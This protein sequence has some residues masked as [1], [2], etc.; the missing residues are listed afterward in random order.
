MD[1]KSVSRRSF[2]KRTAGAAAVFT[3]VPRH[4][5]AKSG[6]TPPSDRPHIASVGAGGQAGHDIAAVSRWADIVALC[7]VDDERATEAF[8]RFPK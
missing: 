5:I 2:L 3:I 6:K 7:D 1:T 8:G 4:V